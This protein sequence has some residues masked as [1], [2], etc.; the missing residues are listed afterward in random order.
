MSMVSWQGQAMLSTPVG[1]TVGVAP[2]TFGVPVVGRM[3]T[4][5]PSRLPPCWNDVKGATSI[6]AMVARVQNSTATITI[7]R[8]I[9]IRDRLQ[10]EALRVALCA[11]AAWRVCRL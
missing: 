7:E 11:Q 4:S 5:L 2:S 8:D 3:R 9:R 6:A 10:A 1:L